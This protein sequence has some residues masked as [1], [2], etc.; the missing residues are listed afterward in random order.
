MLPGPVP[1][2]AWAVCLVAALALVATG[3]NRGAG[4]ERRDGGAVDASQAAGPA[5]LT[6]AD[7]TRE[8]PGVAGGSVRAST[9]D[10]GCSGY[11]TGEPSHVLEVAE[12][13]QVLLVAR[14][15]QPM[16]DLTLV[17]DNG[18]QG[19]DQPARFVCNDD[20]E[21]LNPGLVRELAPGRYR[22]WVGTY[23]A[24]VNA[25]Y[26]LSV[27]A[28]SA[29]VAEAAGPPPARVEGA[30][31]FNGLRIAP[32]SGPGTLSGTAGGPREARTVM[33]GCTG[34]IAMT[35]D[36]VFEIE[37]EMTL[38]VSVTSSDDT[39]LVM[40]GPDGVVLC[41]DDADGLNPGL[42]TTFAA[43]TWSVYVGTWMP[44][45]YPEYT[46]RVAR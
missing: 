10:S 26:T 11:V 13:V 25:A 33:A 8:L 45:R 3:C 9:M 16:H 40:Q 1:G 4:G 14:P 36:H 39:T 6:A 12:P 31:T 17:M 21:G 28:A 22:V 2:L 38:R 37:Q 41:N 29:P 44:S 30:G 7:V 20:H 35:P 23:E 24:G 43:G 15:Q 5:P 34:Y 32:E 18:P 46:L 27:A 42:H 19:G